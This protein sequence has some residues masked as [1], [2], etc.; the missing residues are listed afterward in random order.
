MKKKTVLTAI[1]SIVLI[2]VMLVTTSIE[3]KALDNDSHFYLKYYLLRQVGFTDSDAY[4]IAR[5]DVSMDSGDTKAGAWS[6]NNELWHAMGSQTENQARQN[7]LQ[8]RAE[9]QANEY[10]KTQDPEQLQDPEQRK[11]ALIYFG[12]FLHFL[13][14]R[15]SHEGHG[16]VWHA[17]KLHTPDYLSYVYFYYS[18]QSV[19]ENWLNPMKVF[20]DLL[21]QQTPNPV[22]WNNVSGTVYDVMNANPSPNWWRSP[23]T[24]GIKKYMEELFGLPEDS[25]RL[26]IPY[27]YDKDGNLKPIAFVPVEKFGLTEA[28]WLTYNSTIYD[29]I[30][31]IESSPLFENYIDAGVAVELLYKSIDEMIYL[32]PPIDTLGYAISNLTGL[33]YE[34]EEVMNATTNLSLLMLYRVFMRDYHVTYI[35]SLR[36]VIDRADFNTALSEAYGEIEKAW[37]EI[38]KMETTPHDV[39]FGNL[40]SSLTNSWG[41][42][43]EAEQLALAAGIIGGIVEF[44]QIEEPGTAVPDLSGHNY[45]AS[46]GM[47]V[48]A[49]AGVIALISAAWYIRRRRTKAI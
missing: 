41:Y 5:A 21:L 13:E 33:S 19:V 40:A 9:N 44:P 24:G 14:D 3:V 38:Q 22:T 2:S 1:L 25:L 8:Q 42:L 48:G 26:P 17:Y 34:D 20:F 4:C 32:D 23:K 45:G 31:I 16:W 15:T 49:I 6:S 10:Q 30:D 11:L 12:E 37:T 29:I 36:D 7:Y 46:A 27:N 43:R 39:N 35:G 28:E 18:L 47:I